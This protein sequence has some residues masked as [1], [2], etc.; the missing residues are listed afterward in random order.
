[1]RIIYA[2]W[3]EV[4]SNLQILQVRNWKLLVGNRSYIEEAYS[5]QVFSSELNHK[6]TFLTDFRR[7]NLKQNLNATAAWA[8]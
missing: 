5:I 6:M 2:T 4:L 3:R 1:M 8:M 7:Y